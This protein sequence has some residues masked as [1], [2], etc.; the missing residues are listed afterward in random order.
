MGLSEKI[1]DVGFTKSRNNLLIFKISSV[2]IQLN[3]RG[4]Y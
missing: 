4:D 2:K 3:F 1:H